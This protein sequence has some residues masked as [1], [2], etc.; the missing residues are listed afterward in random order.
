ML[1][2][3]GVLPREA[4]RLPLSALL[5]SSLLGGGCSPSSSDE[6][7]LAPSTLSREQA[8]DQ[9]CDG[10]SVPLSPVGVA[11]N[12]ESGL[13]T[14]CMGV[15]E[16]WLYNIDDVDDTMQDFL[17]V[18]RAQL[19]ATESSFS[20]AALYYSNEY[21]F[22][23]G[24]AQLHH[25]VGVRVGAPVPDGMKPVVR[26]YYGSHD[27]DPT[28]IYNELTAPL[29]SIAG[30]DPANWNVKVAVTRSDGQ[31]LGWNHSKV[32]I[33]DG[34]EVLASSVE[35]IQQEMAIHLAGRTAGHAQHW[36]D[37]IWTQWGSQCRPSGSPLCEVIPVPPVLAVSA[38]HPYRVANVIALR[39]GRLDSGLNTEADD[40]LLAGMDA[41]SKSSFFLNPG[42]VGLSVY[43]Q[44]FSPYLVEKIADRIQ[45]GVDV[46]FVWGD[47]V[48]HPL[49]TTN[50]QNIENTL[51]ARFQ[52]L[53]MTGIQKGIGHCM[54]RVAPYTDSRA[55]ARPQS[56]AKFYMLD[57]SFYVGSQNLYPSGF[58]GTVASPELKEFGFFVDTQ[59]GINDD[60]ADEV[61]DRVVQPIWDRSRNAVV[62]SNY[63]D[64]DSLAHPARISGLAWTPF[65]PAACANDFDLT[66]DFH[67]VEH[68]QIATVSGHTTCSS[69]GLTVSVDITGTIATGGIFQGTIS[70]QLP[71]W[72]RDTAPLTGTLTGG[73]LSLSFSGLEP[74]QGVA[75]SGSVSTRTTP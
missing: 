61:I 57:R 26:F 55:G 1:F 73:S 72:T 15:P 71:G 63:A 17:Q 20:H 31:L 12:G 40:A 21:G 49:D 19:E 68:D 64:C 46:K 52:A 8:L 58:K 48:Q 4:R 75:Y 2:L 51:D 42:L 45:A 24:L 43:N 66:L 25:N 9:Y 32:S 16:H 34:V 38:S 11:V 74:M 53:N 67:D 36:F 54:F 27:A 29:A 70:G 37:I 62:Q 23:A 7:L 69:F 5:V 35:T 10:A 6:K 14:T 59:P 28:F 44:T 60:L 65:G 33:R 41:A 30:S 56:H 39:R 3:R 13:L 22:A 47:A 18:A 50:W